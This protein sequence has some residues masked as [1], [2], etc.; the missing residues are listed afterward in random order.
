MKK[1][2]V[3]GASLHSNRYSNI[4]VKS[5][6]NKGI[7]TLAFGLRGGQ[8]DT[9][10]VLCDP[11]FF[12]TIPDIHSLSLYISAEKQEEYLPLWLDLK[13]QRILFNPGTENPKIYPALKKAGIQAEEACTLVLLSTGQY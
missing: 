6:L 2:I 1:T 13:P 10:A 9:V 7:E 8:I 3:W 12:R 11:D 5:L 4:A